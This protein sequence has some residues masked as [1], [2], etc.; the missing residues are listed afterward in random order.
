MVQNTN[1]DVSG[2]DLSEIFYP[3]SSGGIS[4]TIPTGFK[5]WDV[6][7]GEFKDLIYLFAS[8]NSGSYA[9][10]TNYISGNYGTDLSRIFQKIDN[11]PPIYTISDT[12]GVNITQGQTGNYYWIIFDIENPSLQA[13]IPGGQSGIPGIAKIIFNQN[14]YDVNFII[15]GGGGGGAGGNILSVAGAGGG[16]GATTIINLL[17]VNINDFFNL[18]VGFQGNG[19]SLGNQSGGGNDAGAIGGVSSVE[20][21]GIIFNSFGGRQGTGSGTVGNY[22][23]GAGGSSEITI[24]WQTNGI[25]TSI[26]YGGSGGGGLAKNINVGNFFGGPGGNYGTIQNP[27]TSSKSITGG[28]AGSNGGDGIISNNGGNGGNNLVPTINLV[29]TSPSIPLYIGGGGGGGG[30]NGNGGGGGGNNGNGGQ[31]GIIGVGGIGSGNNNSLGG[32]ASTGY[33]VSGNLYNYGAGGGGGGKNSTPT[34]DAGGNGACGVII[35]YFQMLQPSLPYVLT[36]NYV[37]TPLNNLSGYTNSFTF[38]G[39][40]TFQFTP[41]SFSTTIHVIIVGG[42][43]GGGGGDGGNSS[44]GGGGG[45]GGITTL[46]YTINSSTT[47]IFDIIVGTG[48][49]G[50]SL[51]SNGSIGNPS[52]VTVNSITYTS[53]GGNGGLYTGTCGTGGSYTGTTGGSGGSGGTGGTGSTSTGSTGLTS[54]YISTFG[55]FGGGGG[56]GGTTGGSGALGGGG[57]GGTNSNGISGHSC[58]GGGGGGGSNGFSGGNGSTGVVILYY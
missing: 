35:L 55:Y 36:G 12:S 58:N 45:G 32:S 42:G 24:T 7:S 52:S 17:N 51:N 57:N 15:I 40:G 11:L 39:N 54:S 13:S 3:L 10:Y 25:L 43:G 1:Y 6:S 18:N 5:Y 4:Q 8:Y 53:Y 22:T 41:Q 9:N 49:I 28:N 23:G 34:L 19:R 37:I 33:D 48:G 20:F 30:N 2:L 46:L 21:G 16:S 29:F 27:S 47:T 14:V 50:G 31:A 38:Y 26:G 44:G 56:G